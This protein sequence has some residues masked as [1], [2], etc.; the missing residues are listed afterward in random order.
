VSRRAKI[1]LAL[2]VV[3][4]MVLAMGLGVRER[5][6]D[7]PVY[8]NR[9]LVE[10]ASVRAE[11]ELAPL[12]RNACLD[13]IAQEAAVAYMG[14][15]GISLQVDQADCPGVGD[16]Q[17]LGTRGAREPE[18]LVRFWEGNSR[19]R[20]MLLQP[21]ATQVGLGCARVKDGDTRL[22][23]CSVLVAQPAS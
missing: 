21:D 11:A 19:W 8:A 17:E 5:V 10:I 15:R 13:A 22:V 23:A 4:V 7:G 2:S 14:M 12:A 3:A 16:V 6:P 20:P 9:M 1:V 18:E